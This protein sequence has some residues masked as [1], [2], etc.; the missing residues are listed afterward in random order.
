MTENQPE[1]KPDNSKKI[2]GW[3]C[4]ITV[5]IV[6]ILILICQNNNNEKS[7]NQKSYSSSSFASAM[8]G[9]F[10]LINDENTA[11]MKNT[12]STLN[13]Q[14]FKRNLVTLIRSGTK[15]EIIESKGF[16]SPW[17]YVFVYNNQNTVFA[18]GWIL[19]E[20]VKDAKK[21]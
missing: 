11:V 5:L 12:E 19:A 6:F 15:V 18:K 2:A 4:G 3:G 8:K 21:Q 20:T 1:Q 17:K 14:A 10:W 13:E 7:S 16:L 9:E